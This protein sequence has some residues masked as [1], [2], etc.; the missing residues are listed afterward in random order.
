MGILEYFKEKKKKEAEAKAAQAEAWRIKEENLKKRIESS[1]IIDALFAEFAKHDWILR[2]QSAEDKGEREV[3][4]T[5]DTI[6]I[7][8][9][10]MHYSSRVVGQDK[11]GVNIYKSNMTEEV[12]GHVAY[13]FTKSGYAPLDGYL[14]REVFAEVITNR[15]EAAVQYTY[16]SS[17]NKLGEHDSSYRT[18]TLPAPTQRTF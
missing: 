5:N 10:S 9:F 8:W 6:S 7:K 17:N 18:Y 4:V 13:S 3:C 14:E 15:I 12:H 16:S 2:R 1:P 11:W